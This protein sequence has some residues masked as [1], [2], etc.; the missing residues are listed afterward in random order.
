M[1][2]SVEYIGEKGKERLQNRMAFG[3]DLPEIETCSSKRRAPE[4]EL[5]IDRFG[6]GS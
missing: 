3:R 5:E 6:E 2:S 1:L 4:E